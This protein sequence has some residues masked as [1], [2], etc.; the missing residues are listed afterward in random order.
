[1]KKAMYAALELFTQNPSASW[2]QVAKQL[3]DNGVTLG[4]AEEATTKAM[5]IA[6]RKGLI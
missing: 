3:Q 5:K 2:E 4:Y 6:R 1:M